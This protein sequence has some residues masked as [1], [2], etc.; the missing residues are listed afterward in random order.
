MPLPDRVSQPR[1]HQTRNTYRI[2]IS[3]SHPPEGRL[4]DYFPAPIKKQEG[5]NIDIY[6]AHEPDLSNA[7]RMTSAVTYKSQEQIPL[8]F[9]D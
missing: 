4:L 7:V 3:I 2:V 5:R 6:Y 9:R 1:P 8:D